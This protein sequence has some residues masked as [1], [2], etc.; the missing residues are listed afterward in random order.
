MNEASSGLNEIMGKLSEA[1]ASLQH[2]IE[3]LVAALLAISLITV[4]WEL[5]SGNGSGKKHLIA[6]VVALIFSL[7]FI[8]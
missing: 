3:P 5:S 1:R 2:V 8:F 7:L 4:V 6:W